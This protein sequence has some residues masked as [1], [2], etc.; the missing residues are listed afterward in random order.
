MKQNFEIRVISLE[1]QLDRR[2]KISSILNETPLS[3]QF[4]DA[5]S[6]KNI[7]PYISLYNSERRLKVFGY[8]MKN[9]EI[10]CFI[11]HRKVWQECVEN[12]KAYLILE[13]D[14]KLNRGFFDFK[15]VVELVN[16]IIDSRADGVYVR[17]G[18]LSKNLKFIVMSQLINSIELVRFEKDPLTAMAYVVSPEI[19]KKLIK[20][21]ES[22]FT[23]V[24][25][26]MWRGWEHQCCLLDV[27]PSV[28]YTSDED[29]PSN[30]G[31]RLKPEIGFLNKIKRE[32][33]R[34]FDNKDKIIYEKKMLKLKR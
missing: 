19:A 7:A 18:V 9:N 14:V 17:L 4:M 1:N 5:V 29:T 2:R 31:E 21:S 13:D 22:F 11:S 33:H 34:F 3:W 28:F 6:G 16:K 8:E 10:A 24:D 26:F 27:M 15:E 25:D 20:Y 12:Q 23:P 32:Y 30:I